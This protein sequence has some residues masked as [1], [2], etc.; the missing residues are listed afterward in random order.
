M[1]YK[2]WRHPLNDLEIIVDFKNSTG[3]IKED[4][5]TY[6]VAQNNIF[7]LIPF[8]WPIIEKIR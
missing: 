4:Q 1:L 2:A 6:L 7:L 3:N 5:G 8:A